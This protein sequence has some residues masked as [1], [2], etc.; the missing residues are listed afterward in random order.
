MKSLPEARFGSKL[1]DPLVGEG[2][3][4][5]TRFPFGVLVFKL[6]TAEINQPRTDPYDGRNVGNGVVVQPDSGK[7]ASTR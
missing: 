5:N 7:P 4:V 1:S 2:R 6:R 3:G